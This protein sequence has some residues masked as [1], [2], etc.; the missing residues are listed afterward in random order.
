MLKVDRARAREASVV[1]VGRFVDKRRQAQ[2]AARHALQTIAQGLLAR[3]ARATGSS[4]ATGTAA[5]TNGA[6][7]TG[8]NAA[9][10]ATAATYADREI[11]MAIH[12]AELQLPDAWIPF[13]VA[14]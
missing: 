6:A 11:A 3:G 14:R 9:A 13:V 10:D 12:A 1:G 5:A 2:I 4:A 8:T 7:A